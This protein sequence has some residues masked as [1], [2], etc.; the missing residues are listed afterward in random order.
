MQIRTRLTLQF[1]LLGGMIMIVASLAIYFSSAGFRRDDFYNR[2]RSKAR[3]TARLVI[4]AD[5]PDTSQLK[6]I[7]KDFPYN[8]HNEKIVILNYLNDIIFTTDPKNEIIIRYDILEKIRLY[9]RMFYNQGPYE[10]LGT[11]YTNPEYR[12]VVLAAATDVEG[13][14]HLKQLR[15]ILLLVFVTCLLLFY[16]AGTLFAGRALKP[17]N[18]V[19]SRVE[20]IS[21]T[22][23]DLRVPEG[24]GNDEIGR[25]A[26]NFNNML[27]RLQVS[28]GMQKDFI[29]NA[30]HELRTPLTSINGQLEV[31]MIRD[32]TTE[33]YKATIASV[34]EDIKALINLTNRLLLLAR[35]TSENQNTAKTPVRIDEV[36]WQVKDVL[37]KYNKGYHV[38]ISLDPDLNDSDQ[39]T[40]YGDEYLLR[41]AFLNI[42]DNACKYSPDNQVDIKLRQSENS[43]EVAFRNT[44]AGISQTEINRILEPFYR[45]DKVKGIPGHG[46]GLTLVNQIVN[47]HRGKLEIVSTEGEGTEVTIRLEVVPRVR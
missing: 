5:V 17:I 28:F 9:Q 23:L 39:M 16:F 1:M 45:S 26:R 3:L 31:L 27:Q 46:I 22:S 42:A 6:R 40:V 13:L 30:S 12:Y 35:T 15:L 41:T 43:I 32:R 25:L 2:L 34:L 29:A 24:N 44:G 38:N 36:L 14:A 10:V 21:I 20:E 19:V 7:D 8:L 47:I 37:K 11:L 4:D 18:D 33:E